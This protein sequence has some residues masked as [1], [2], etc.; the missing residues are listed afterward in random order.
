MN[1]VGKVLCRSGWNNKSR[2]FVE[3]LQ[4]TRLYSL[5]LSSLKFSNL[6]ILNCR[7]IFMLTSCE[8]FLAMKTSTAVGSYSCISIRDKTAVISYSK[9]KLSSLGFDL[10]VE[11]QKYSPSSPLGPSKPRSPGGPGGPMKPGRPGCPGIPEMPRSPSSPTS[12]CGPIGP[13]L[14][15]SR[16]GSYKPGLPGAPI[17]NKIMITIWSI[18]FNNNELC[19]SK[20]FQKFA[21]SIELD[22]EICLEFSFLTIC[23][24]KQCLSQ[25]IKT[26]YHVENIQVVVRIKCLLDR[27]YEL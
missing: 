24:Q 9:A 4:N 5:S 17:R 18:N 19:T 27:N 6:I 3:S 7:R 8:R 16:L 10:I 26:K 21:S 23:V 12:P 15:S 22:V 13:T 25:W 14:I 11:N 20:L 2:R 1:R